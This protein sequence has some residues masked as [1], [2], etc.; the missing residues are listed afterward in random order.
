M[1]S[2]LLLFY[3]R[4]GKKD[5]MTLRD[6]LKKCFDI[7][8]IK[9][10]LLKALKA[11]VGDNVDLFH[12]SYSKLDFSFASKFSNN[13]AEPPSPITPNTPIT[14]S[15]SKLDMNA[16]EKETESN[17]RKWTKDVNKPESTEKFLESRHLIDIL[18]HFDGIKVTLDELL[19]NLR[20]L[21]PRLYSV[22]SAFNKSYCSITAGVVFSQMQG[23]NRRG[24]CGNFLSQI[25]EGDECAIFFNENQNFRLP[26]SV[27]IPIIMIGA[28]TGVAPMR[29]FIQT[30]AGNEDPTNI[31]NNLFFGCRYSARDYLY[32]EEFE[33]LSAQEQ[34]NLV[35]SFSREGD[36]KYIQNKVLQQSTLIW[37]LLGVGAHI[38][39]C[40]NKQMGKDVEDTIEQ[41]IKANSHF[42]DTALE[43][44]MH[45]LKTNK[46]LQMDVW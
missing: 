1:K 46:R 4:P 9:I 18:K 19:T 35:V 13:L 26:K 10:S 23:E 6:V 25:K 41:I 28:G 8:N 45:D 2:I 11:H 34:L 40:G 3:N 32:K 16:L 22:S 17:R 15:K 12:K 14:Q 7:R 20:P 24:V 36:K 39:V 38:Y 42:Y 30:R 5:K 31:L 43:D 37:E 27:E 33:K 29:S 44:Y 21:I